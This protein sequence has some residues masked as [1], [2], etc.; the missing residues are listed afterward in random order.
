M[1][2]ANFNLFLYSLL[3]VIVNIPQLN[4]FSHSLFHLCH[5]F[6]SQWKEHLN[7]NLESHSDV[8]L[9]LLTW[10]KELFFLRIR[11]AD[12]DFVWTSRFPYHKH[13]INNQFVKFP[14]HKYKENRSAHFDSQNLWTEKIFQMLSFCKRKNEKKNHKETT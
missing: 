6:L 12:K 1:I 2:I 7:N 13:L 9:S 14:E 5:L 10:N 4:V 11:R 3:F 8:I